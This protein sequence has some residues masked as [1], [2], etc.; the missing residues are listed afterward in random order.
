ML[1][2]SVC[3]CCVS[4]VLH[5]MLR[6]CNL[7]NFQEEEGN[8]FALRAVVVVKEKLLGGDGHL[9]VSAHVLQL[10]HD[11]SDLSQLCR[12]QPRVPMRVSYNHLLYQYHLYAYI[13]YIYTYIYISIC[14][15]M[16]HQSTLTCQV[17]VRADSIEQCFGGFSDSLHPFARMFSG[18]QQWV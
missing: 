9:G 2:F 18:W 4:N 14:N 12:T 10:I 6:K 5:L 13:I 15:L 7:H 17:L 11:A 3:L 1:Q 8:D 16:F